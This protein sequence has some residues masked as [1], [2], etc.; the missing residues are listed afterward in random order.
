VFNLNSVD[1][2]CTHY[3]NNTEKHGDESV[4]TGDISITVNI[5]NAQ[6]EQFDS[7]LRDAMYRKAL[8]N[9]EQ[10]SL[11]DDTPTALRLPRIKSWKWSDEY[12]G[13]ELSIAAGLALAEALTFVDVNVKKGFVLTPQEGGTVAVNFTARVHPEDEAEAGRLCFLAG[14]PITLTFTPPTRAAADSAQG[15][16]LDTAGDAA[17]DQLQQASDALERDAA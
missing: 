16:L 9:G 12:T 5:P 15:D 14:K 10:P 1:A 6:L 13:C 4:T 8:G 17:N 11:V 3:S 2:V 7:G